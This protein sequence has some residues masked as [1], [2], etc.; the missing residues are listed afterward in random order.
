MIPRFTRARVTP[1]R[2]RFGKNAIV[3][4]ESE[5]FRP[6]SDDGALLSFRLTLV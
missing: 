3:A 4:G 2:L 5:F 1:V 6:R